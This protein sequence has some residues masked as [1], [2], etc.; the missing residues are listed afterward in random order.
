MGAYSF[1]Y[2]FARQISLF[3]VAVRS[4]KVEQ[5]NVVSHTKHVAKVVKI[6]RLTATLYK[7]V[8]NFM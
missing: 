5:S 3:E 4:G 2:W 6:Y 1:D 8:L 7:K